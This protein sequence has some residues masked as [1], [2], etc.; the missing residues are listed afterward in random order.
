MAPSCRSDGTPIGEHHSHIPH[1]TAGTHELPDSIES[2]LLRAEGCFPCG[3][4]LEE[5][6]PVW[7]SP[8]YASWTSREAD[9]LNPKEAFD[10]FRSWRDRQSTQQTWRRPRRTLVL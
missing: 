7:N 1:R 8:D 4:A 10:E 2:Q 6:S 9:A 5:R 3:S